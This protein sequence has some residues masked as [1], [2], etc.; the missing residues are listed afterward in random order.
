VQKASVALI[1]K[2]NEFSKP[3]SFGVCMWEMVARETP[4]EGSR[5][6]EDHEATT[7]GKYLDH[8]VVPESSQIDADL[9]SQLY[10]EMKSCWRSVS[11][12]SSFIS[13]AENFTRRAG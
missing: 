10:G 7:G 6:K 8:P 5:N 12:G 2:T 3:Y 1:W 4:R 11:R 13:H 9:L